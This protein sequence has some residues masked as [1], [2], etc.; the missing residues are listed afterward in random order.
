MRTFTPNELEKLPICGFEPFGRCP[1][2]D[3]IDL[4]HCVKCRAEDIMGAL[5]RRDVATAA[6]SLVTLLRILHKMDVLP[7]NMKFDTDE[8]K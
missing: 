1:P 8:L 6:L 5:Q 4:K 2:E 3:K 7:E